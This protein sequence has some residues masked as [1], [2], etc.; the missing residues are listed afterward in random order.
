MNTIVT[1][2]IVVPVSY[3]HLRYSLSPEAKLAR[4][5]FIKRMKAIGAEIEIDDRCV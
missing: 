2:S 4:E 3:T 1:I 5:E